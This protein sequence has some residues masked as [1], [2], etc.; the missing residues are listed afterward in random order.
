[1][2]WQNV[3]NIKLKKLLLLST[4]T[5]LLKCFPSLYDIQLGPQIYYSVLGYIRR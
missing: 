2:T 1:M 4:F 3:G 5:G